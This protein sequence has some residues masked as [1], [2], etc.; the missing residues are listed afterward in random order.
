MFKKLNI[1]HGITLAV[2]FLVTLAL[3]IFNVIIIYT[4][5][6][7][8][9]DT[10]KYSSREINK[11]VIMNYENYIDE[12][13]ETANYISTR[14]LSLTIENDLPALENIY[15]QATDISRDIVSIVLLSNT[16]LEIVNSNTQTVSSDVASKS[17]F[18]KAVS[19]PEIFNFSTPHVQDIYHDS[20]RQVITISKTISYQDT[21]Q[22]LQTGVL[23]IDLNIANIIALADKTNLGENGHI[24]IISDTGEYV[25]SNKDV[26]TLGVC[27]S[28]ELADELIF[29]GQIVDVDSTKMYLNVNTLAHTRW[30]IATFVNIQEIY[31]SQ[32]TI[33][34]ISIGL[35]LV[36]LLSS[37][38]IALGLSRRI[39][40][41]IQQL[42]D[43]MNKLDQDFIL[44]EIQ[45]SGQKEVVKLSESFNDMI[46]EIRTLMDKLVSEQKEK[47]KSEFFALQMQINPHFLYNTL[48][49]IVWLA[50]KEKNQDVIEMVIALSR[51]FRIS[52]SKGKNIIPAAQE[53]EHAKNYLHIQKIRYNRQFDFEFDID[54][55]IYQYQVVKLILQP[56]IENA[57]NHGISSEESGGFIRI[58][59]TL[60]NGN[61]CFEVINNG[62]G[63]T[64]DQIDTMYERM[65]EAGK[66]QSVG[67]RNVYQRMKIYYGD[68]ADIIVSSQMDE[69]TSIKL[70]IPARKDA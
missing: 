12:V 49:S 52:I 42:S 35:F 33:I 3:L 45:L 29:G 28:R 65:K 6:T 31:N 24:I 63:L 46:V 26:C 16:G 54:E 7:S 55:E 61:I 15:E 14:T 43:H 44:E 56:I 38:L 34:V 66:A 8:S 11:Q 62:Y 60:E 23:S 20:V 22:E 67:L 53:I 51:F 48:D 17:W 21:A 64:N 69:F 30:R 36:A 32:T 70:V 5:R 59:A 25:Y 47:R 2:M 40:N 4:F 27:E 37:Y 50:E 9:L 19:N 10:I 13:I 39:S 41:P 1:S 18:E 58:V 57:I 68:S